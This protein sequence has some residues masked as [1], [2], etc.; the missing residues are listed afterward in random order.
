MERDVCKM[1]V[2]PYTMHFTGYLPDRSRLEF[3]EDI[4]RTGR[5]VIV[6]DFLNEQV[7]DLPLEFRIVRDDGG[8]PEQAEPVFRAPP[9]R[10]PS[11]SAAFQFRVDQPGRFVGVVAVADTSAFVS[12]FPFSVGESRLLRHLAIGGGALVASGLGI[13]IYANR[14][15]GAAI[16]KALA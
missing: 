10:Y 1:Y 7:R 13:F 9:R 11:G 14:R 3:C 15:R 16:R 2:G 12:V 4:P 6:L 8:N 5:V